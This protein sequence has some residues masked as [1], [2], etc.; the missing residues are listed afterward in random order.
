MKKNYHQK[1]FALLLI[2]FLSTPKVFAKEELTVIQTVSKDRKSF[3]VAKG[4]KEGVTRGQEIIFAND[5]VSIVCKASLVDRDYS[6]WV[7]LDKNITIPFNKEEIV[8]A[9]SSVYGNVALEVVTAPELTPKQK[10][11]AYQIF[12]KS[13]SFDAKL[14]YNRGLSQSSTFIAEEKNATRAGYNYALNYNYRFMPEFEISAGL[15]VDN[16]VYRIEEPELDIPT[17]RRMIT[18]SA[19]YHF[20][21]LSETRNNFFVTIAAGVGTSETNVNE[22]ISTGRAILLPEVRVGFLMPFSQSMALSFETS[23]ESMSTKE[24]FEDGT[25]QSSNAINSRFSIGLRF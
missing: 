3:V 24:K 4:L 22:D 16:E 8:S 12:I 17:T 2:A 7:P 6:L 9:N 15:R 11:K 13:N 25:E 18:A 20:L 14:S 21:G 19:T 1:L 10:D 23:I 5:N